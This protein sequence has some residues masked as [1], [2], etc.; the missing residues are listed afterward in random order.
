LITFNSLVA[1]SS[2]LQWLRS[3][4]DGARVSVDSRIK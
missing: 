3:A 1:F 2:L 4:A